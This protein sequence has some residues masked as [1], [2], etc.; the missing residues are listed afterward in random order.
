MSEPPSTQNSQA[1]KHG[2]C[3]RCGRRYGGC[4][5]MGTLAYNVDPEHAL[6]IRARYELAKR[7]AGPDDWDRAAEFDRMVFTDDGFVP[8]KVHKV[9][10]NGSLTSS[11]EGQDTQT[12]PTWSETL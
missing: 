3:T 2:T 12:D 1:W 9:S 6:R 7:F 11:Y 10:L 8:S 5:H 4:P